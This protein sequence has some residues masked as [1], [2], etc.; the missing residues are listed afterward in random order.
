M[1]ILLASIATLSFAACASVPANVA[2]AQS[3]DML[4]R[5]VTVIDPDGRTSTPVQ[6]VYILDGRIVEIAD[7]G[8]SGRVAEQVTE[9][10]GRYLIPGL[11]DMHAHTSFRPVHQPSLTLM[12]AN[13]V[14]GVREM[15]SDCVD[16]EGIAMCIG[17]MRDAH[18]QIVAGEI[19]GPRMLELSSSKIDSNRPDDANAVQAAYRPISAEDAE[20]TIAFMQ[21]RGADF[22][23]TGDE[24]RPE[25]FATFARVATEQD[26]RFGGHVPPYLS[27]ADVANMGMTSIEHARDLPLDCSTYGSEFRA[28]VLAALSGERES[29]PNRMEMAARSRDTFDETICAGQIE[30]MR[31]NGTYYVPTHLTREMDYRAGDE[32]YRNDPR[33]DYIMAMQQRFWFQDMDRTAERLG[34]IRSDLEDFFNLGLRTTGLAHAAGV[35]IMAGTDANDTMVFPGFSLHDELRHLVAAGLSP[36]D[37]LRAATSVPA[38]YLGRESDFGGVSEGRMADLILLRADPLADI[39]NTREIEAVFFGGRLHDRA[40]LDAML[41]EVRAWVADADASM[42]AQADD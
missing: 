22:L 9:G 32:D 6:D 17:E 15:G 38:A 3:A 11:M 42:A 18:A 39:G 29:F 26:M 20:V 19:V 37:A 16:P 40:A 7:S 33:F 14:T 31:A 36:M 28:G 27:V 13:G 21:E 35:Q 10:E 12:L 5:N 2:M 23:K 25:A 4:I 30:A 8:S 1:R 34:P 41:A 24:F